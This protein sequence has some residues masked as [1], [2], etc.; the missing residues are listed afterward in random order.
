MSTVEPRSLAAGPSRSLGRNTQARLLPV[1]EE[2]PD[3]SANRGPRFWIQL[4]V[5]LALIVGGLVALI[6]G[7]GV[8]ICAVIVLIGMGAVGQLFRGGDEVWPT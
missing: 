5:G 2:G 4:V 7:M 1:V 8:P 6:A 3:P